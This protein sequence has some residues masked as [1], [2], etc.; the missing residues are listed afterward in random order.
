MISIN[1]Y[2]VQKTNDVNL[3]LICHD[4]INSNQSYELPECNHVYHTDCIIQWFRT[5]NSNCPYCNSSYEN[6][7]NN[8]NNDNYISYSMRR[9]KIERDYT[10][11]KR[12]SKK[13]ESP[14]ILQ[15]MVNSIEKMKEQHQILKNELKNIK[16]ENGKYIDL[17]KK[18]I[19]IRQK[20]YKKTSSIYNK[21][22]DLINMVNIIP[23]IVPSKK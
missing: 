6:N 19:T 4:D 2:N 23:I 13:K 15:K 20:I 9:R 7:D 12:F 8:N 10:I 18:N 22:M 3:C 17:Q 5:G 21:K 16:N 11:I 1:S 14:K